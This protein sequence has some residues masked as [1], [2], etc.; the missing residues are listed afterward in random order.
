MNILKK[1]PLIVSL[2]LSLTTYAQN[3]KVNQDLISTPL[4][5]STNFSLLNS[6]LGSRFS[7]SLLNEKQSMQTGSLGFDMDEQ[8]GLLIGVYV[9]GKFYCFRT[10]KLPRNATYLKNQ[11]LKFGPTS[12]LISGETPEG[13]KVDFTLISSFTPSKDLD[14][15]ENIKTQIFPGFYMQVNVT[16]QSA[17]SLSNCKLKIALAKTPVKGFNFMSLE[18]MKPDNT[19]QTVLFRDNASLNGK[20]ALAAIKNP[21]KGTFNEE[22]FGGLFYEF[23]LA[24]NEQKDFTQ[25]YATYHATTVIEDKRVNLPLKFYY[26]SYWKNI[27][28]VLQ[29]AKDNFEQNINLTQKFEDNLMNSALTAQEKWVLALTFHTDLA[30]TFFLLDENKLTRFYVSE[31]RFKHLSTVDVAHETEVSAIFCP[32]RLKL[33]LSQWTNYIARAELTITANPVQNKPAYQQ[34]MTAAEYGPY[35]YHDVGD[36]P[37]VSETANYNYGPHMAVE[38]NTSFVLLLY[39]YWKISHDDAFVKSMLGTVDVLLQSVAN[40]DTNG[41]GIADKAY[42]W[43]TYDA[44]EALKL[45]PD[46]TFLGAKQLSAYAVAAEMFRGL[47]NKE[48]AKTIDAT[49]KGVVDGEGAGYK[50]IG[51]AVNNEFLRNKQA[52]YFEKEANLILATLKKAQKKYGFIPVS[53]DESFPKWNQRSVVIGEGLFLPGLVGVKSPILNELATVLKKDYIQTYEESITDYGIKLTTQEGTTWFSKTIV[54]DIVAQQWYG[55]KH[56]SAPYI[57]KWNKNSPY[58]YNDGLLKKDDVW[59]GYWYPRGIS[60]LGYWILQNPIKN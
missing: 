11:Q 29:Y 7:F 25:I 41:N 17:K 39:Y 13:I 34:G 59:I 55:I 10:T 36:L 27:N 9:N 47:T 43:T 6:R 12:M 35:L 5:D 22:G 44:N 50:N 15:I 30:N 20:L 53:L 31:G 58:A 52:R 21:A 4:T 14:D 46:N 45:S 42:G 24:Q 60:M 19:E 18:P 1:L 2:S 38:E 23:N 37:F 48:Q 8:T 28:E 16:N 57:Y 51:I 56:S 33:Q 40:R 49:K 54:A 3:F 26:T 32:W